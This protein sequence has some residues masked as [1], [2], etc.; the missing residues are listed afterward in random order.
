MAKIIEKNTANEINNGL[1]MNYVLGNDINSYSL[2]KFNLNENGEYVYAGMVKINSIKEYNKYIRTYNAIAKYIKQSYGP[3]ISRIYKNALNSLV[4]EK[5]PYTVSPNRHSISS[6]FANKTFSASKLASENSQNYADTL[7]F[8]TKAAYYT[9]RL[10]PCT[11]INKIMQTN[12]REFANSYDVCVLPKISDKGVVLQQNKLNSNTLEAQFE[13]LDRKE[14]K[15]IE[16]YM[17][18]TANSLDSKTAENLKAQISKIFTASRNIGSSINQATPETLNDLQNLTKSLIDLVGVDLT[19]YEKNATKRAKKHEKA[20]TQNA[21]TSVKTA[22]V[23]NKV[24]ADEILIRG[25]YKATPTVQGD[26]IVTKITP[27]GVKFNVSFD[28]NKLFV[29][30]EKSNDENSFGM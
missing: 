6:K 30:N 18:E 4:A 10:K 15:A 5:D 21:S 20:Q 22:T 11:E 14:V 25:T 17:L 27:D 8:I 7:S 26:V 1:K 23:S 13:L 2:P 16:N 24:N 19:A 28:G 3:T 29:A 12:E 9:K